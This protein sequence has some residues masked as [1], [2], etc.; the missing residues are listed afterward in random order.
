MKSPIYFDSQVQEHEIKKSDLLDLTSQEAQMRDALKT[1]NQ[2]I[3]DKQSI[4][5]LS[6]YS[7]QE[8]NNNDIEEHVINAIKK[9][10]DQGI[11][12]SNKLE[13][14]MLKLKS[15]LL[16]TVSQSNRDTEIANMNIS[17]LQDIIDKLNSER[18]E[19]KNSVTEF[20]TAKAIDNNMKYEYRSHHLQYFLF[21]IITIIVFALLF[22]IQTTQSSGSME[23]VILVIAVLFLVYHFSGWII[24]IL[25][26]LWS[27]LKA[28]FYF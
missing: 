14:E 5:I 11:K 1:Y 27:W 17:G 23:F 16:N 20:N 19:I 13:K 6:S 2:F 21:F 22:R 15:E 25:N 10:N 18:D 9:W 24:S 28:I 4:D 7:I 12:V 8:D 3:A 26:Y